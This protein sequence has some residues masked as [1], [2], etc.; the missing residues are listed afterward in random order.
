MST[1]HDL[2]RRDFMLR[3]AA[4][5]A[6]LGLLLNG[7][8]VPL[9]ASPLPMPASANERVGL[10]FIGAGIRGHIL[11]EMA[12]LTGQADLVAVCDCYQGHLDRAKE[13]TEGKIETIFAQYKK[14]L[15]RKD[16]DAVVIATPDHWHLQMVLDALAAGKD[17]YIE[18]PMTHRIEDGPKMIAAAKRHN[19]IVQVGSQWI[20]SAQHKK[21]KEIVQAGKLGKVTKITAAYNRNSSTGAW[22]YPIP[23]DLKV[24]EN[25][26]WEEW[27][28]P[29]KKRPF[30]PEYVF[31][32]RKYWDFSGGISTD[33]FVHLINSI[34]FIMGVEMP[35][36]VVATGAIL[37]RNDGRE[38]PDTLD[39]LFDYGSF[40]VNMAS[41]FNSASTAG[42]G[43]QLLGTDASLNLL[44]GTPAMTMAGES[45]REGYSYSIDSWP[46]ALQEQFMN[47]GEHRAESKR[48]A[49]KPEDIQSPDSMD[50]AALHMANFF[51]GVRS[52]KPCAEPPEVGHHAAAAGHMVNLSYRQ[53][54][55]MHWDA[56]KGAARS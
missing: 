43:I 27:L 4:G 16:V 44:L 19:R 11:M 30:N 25:M 10:G 52:R 29:A 42:Q 5:A 8:P 2:T 37:A 32:Y 6:G 3:G 18:K 53:G 36:S 23:P 24:G 1:H 20:S 49:P 38:V 33:L 39:A 14:L 15:E 34:H 47:E 51:D 31:R 26:N 48:E 13:R 45:H 21:A 28:G 46:K 54:K 40:H 35:K 12:K 50:A 56:A 17:V 41:T 55:K 9:E 22:N 7:E